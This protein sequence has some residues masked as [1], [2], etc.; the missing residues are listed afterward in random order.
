MIVTGLVSS[1][2]A[3]KGS[4]D[5]DTFY[6]SG[7]AV[8]EN[9]SM[10]Y[11]G[12]YYEGA[13]GQAP[14]LYAPIASI[15]FTPFALMPIQISAF[16]WNLFLACLF[17]VNFL[18]L[19]SL[20][21]LTKSELRI[22]WSNF[23]KFDRCLY[24]A[25][26]LA[27]LLDNLAMAQIN[28][29]IITF[30]L[31][32]LYFWN[33]KKAFLGG[34]I[35]SLAILFKLTPL[36]FAFYFL[37]KRQ[38]KMLA[39]TFLGLLF[40]TLIIP[41]F[42]FGKEQNRLYHRQWLGRTLKPLYIG[43]YSKL[44]PEDPHPKKQSADLIQNNHLTELLNE[45]NQALKGVLTRLFLKN[46]PSYGY[47]SEPIYVAR[48]YEKMPVILGGLPKEPL[49]FLIFVL[50]LSIL[51]FLIFQWARCGKPSPWHL[52]AEISTVFSAMTLLSPV[53]RSH[54][55]VAWIVPY[56]VLFFLSDPGIKSSFETKGRHLFTLA[57][58]SILIYFL[59]VLP[60]GKAVGMG[61]WANAFILLASLR[62]LIQTKQ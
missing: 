28:I 52:P 11:Q 26:I 7:Q 34:T 30:C 12:E 54:Q 22:K 40:F 14:F 25:I 6:L 51:G 37:I 4:N 19:F 58:I 27:L 39:F 1:H 62:F 50:Q 59:Q 3:K 33:H 9:H 5:F 55:F 32:S 57:K 41:G 49:F 46:R 61:F 21:R 2:R 38:W 15:F 44:H 18:F 47:Q 23:S 56:T 36:L 24:A 31:A 13:P 48:R 17:A 16:L 35:L 29:L 20:C 42:I 43:Y 10:Y 60:Y 45:K 8:L 53:A